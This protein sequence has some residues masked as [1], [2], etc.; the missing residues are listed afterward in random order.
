MQL[1][2]IVLSFFI[3]FIKGQ[4]GINLK[5]YFYVV[6]FAAIYFALI[7]NSRNALIGI[8]VSFLLIFSFKKNIKIYL[9]SGGLVFTILLPILIDI[10]NQNF[11]NRGNM[12]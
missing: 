11:M 8:I 3:S 10:S 12:T 4:V 9:F 6:S 7:T 5:N 2:L 1:W